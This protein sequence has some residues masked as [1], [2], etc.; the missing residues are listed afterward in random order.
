MSFLLAN[1]PFWLPQVLEVTNNLTTCESQPL[2][3]NLLQIKNYIPII[4][5]KKKQPQVIQL[6]YN[7]MNKN[8]SA[9]DNQVAQIQTNKATVN[10]MLPKS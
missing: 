7:K 8:T 3:F 5:E 1:S 4:K 6:K 10:S 2:N 9:V